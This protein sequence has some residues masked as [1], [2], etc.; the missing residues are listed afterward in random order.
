MTGYTREP[1]EVIGLC[2]VGKLWSDVLKKDSASEERHALAVLDAFSPKRYDVYWT[3]KSNAPSVYDSTHRRSGCA[4]T[5]LDEAA[6]VALVIPMKQGSPF[7]IFGDAS[8]FR[9]DYTR[10]KEHT[11]EGNGKGGEI[12]GSSQWDHW[13]I[14]WLNSQGHNVTKETLP[15]YPDH[16]SPIGMDFFALP[17]EVEEQGIYYSLYGVGGH[18]LEAVRT[19]A[20]QWLEKGPAAIIQ[21]GSLEN[22][23]VQPAQEPKP[24]AEGAQI[25][26]FSNGQMILTIQEAQRNGRSE[27]WIHQVQLKLPDGSQTILEGVDGGEFSTSLGGANATGCEVVKNDAS[28]LKLRLS[29]KQD[30]WEAEEEYEL[31]AASSVLQRKQTYRF[32]KPFEGAIHPGFRLK[33]ESDIRYTF[34]LRVHE[35]PLSGLKP[36]RRAVE[37]AVPLPFHLWHNQKY[38]ALYGL[39]KRGSPGTLDFAPVAEDGR[40]R[41]RVYYPDSCP[42][43]VLSMFWPPDADTIPGTTK[44]AEG[45]E[46]TLTEII[47]AKPLAAGDDPLLESERIAASILLP[48]L[49]HPVKTEG[50]GGWRRQLPETLRS[51]GNQRPGAGTGL[52]LCHVDRRH[53]RA[54]IQGRDVRPG[55]GDGVCRGKLDGRRPLLETHG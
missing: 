39:D 48:K 53:E 40:A 29:G 8:G 50:R 34:P 7:C 31:A 5:E 38:V 4:W 17:N 16:F 21:P 26:S 22:L 18:D 32:L 25:K 54:R 36:Q 45:A 9:H 52:V 28:G 44:F 15:L 43:K 2:P 10:L 46:L 49:P 13:P 42:D 23:T 35:Q 1:I 19:L 37:W 12:W 24:A 3:P 55:V 41:L 11:F 27:F 33:A 30:A 20:R 51:V 14:G 47:A 6:G